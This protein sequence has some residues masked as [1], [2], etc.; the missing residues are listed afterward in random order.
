MHPYSYLHNARLV[1]RGSRY[2]AGL[3]VGGLHNVLGHP[4]VARLLEVIAHGYAGVGEQGLLHHKY[5]VVVLDAC[6]ILER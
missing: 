6:A 4:G 2:L 3:H 5:G 1:H